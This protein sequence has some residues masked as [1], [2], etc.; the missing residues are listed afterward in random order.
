M[1]RDERWLKGLLLS[2]LVVVVTGV[3][4]LAATDRLRGAESCWLIALA[5]V[6]HQCEEHVFTEWA[7]GR[8][9]AFLPWIHT[10]GYQLSPRRALVLNI[11]LAWSLALAS[12]GI[13]YRWPSVP[14]FVIA[15]EVVN[16]FWHL[17]VTSLQQRWAPGTLSSVVLTIPLGFALFHDSLSAGRVDPVMLG[18]LFGAAV[19]SHHLFLGSLPRVEQAE[20]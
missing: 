7:L 19:V 2:G 3:S 1:E 14:L 15:V 9:Q 10:L 5:M 8:R 13:G 12:G 4:W 17:S 16:G 18:V 6:V 20:A 11:G